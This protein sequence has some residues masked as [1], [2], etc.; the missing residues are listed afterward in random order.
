LDG[1]GKYRIKVS[2]SGAG[3]KIE[4]LKRYTTGSVDLELPQ[5]THLEICMRALGYL[6]INLSDQQLVQYAEGKQTN[7]PGV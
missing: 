5:Q 3:L 1:S 7:T 6:G 4:D 2:T